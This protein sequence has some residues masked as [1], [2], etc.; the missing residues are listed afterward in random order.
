MLMMMTDTTFLFFLLPISFIACFLKSGLQKLVLLAI[1]LYFYSVGSPVYFLLFLDLTVINT[2]AAYVIPLCRSEVPKKALLIL[3]IVMNAGLLFY[4]KYFDFTIEIF[5]GVTGSSIAARDL[6]LP[7]GISFFTFKSISLLIDVYKGKVTLQKNP[8]YPLLYLSFFGQIVSGPI[9]RYEDFYEEDDSSFDI[10][11]KADDFTDG[12]YLFMRGFCKKVLIANVMSPLV[13]EIFGADPAESSASLL[14][15]GS[16]IYSLQLYY[17]FS[18]YSDMA[19]GI[20][21]IFG[22][23][24]H[25]NFNYPYCTQSISEF[26]RRWHITLGRWFRDYIYIPLGGSRSGGKWRVYFNLFVVWLLTGIWHGANYTFIFWG[27]TYFIAISA[28]KYLGLP[29]RLKSGVSKALYRVFTLIF[30]NLEWVMFN[31]SD[32]KNG[33][34]Y[35]FHMFVSGGSAMSDARAMAILQEYGIILIAAVVFATPVIPKIKEMLS[36]HEGL[37]AKAADVCMAC[38]LAVLFI[39]SISF[40]IAGQNNPFLYGNF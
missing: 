20:G 13:S 31:S 22:I 6:L 27:L 39:F 36:D 3:G 14:W 8:V 5:N 33:L 24:C 40:V 29:D 21:R 25:E 17:D 4:Y 11:Q 23:G 28:E 38:V 19:I 9:G 37:P 7:M 16:V 10:R 2:C 12:A 26:W 18:G 35:I 15:L 34:S 32:I 30:I 1:S